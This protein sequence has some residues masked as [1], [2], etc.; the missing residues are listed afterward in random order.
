MK[1]LIKYLLLKKSLVI[2]LLVKIISKLKLKKRN[3]EI[4]I[5]V[6]LAVLKMKNKEEL[7]TQIYNLNDK[8]Y[9]FKYPFIIQEAT[10]IDVKNNT[11]VTGL[12]LK[13]WLLGSD[14]PLFKVDK[15][16][17]LTINK[18]NLEN[19]S[20]TIMPIINMY[21]SI[22]STIEFNDVKNKIIK[23]KKQVIIDQLNK[24]YEL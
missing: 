24:M 12:Q 8:Q 1:T 18:I 5:N 4:K 11:V 6:D 16:D 15:K 23:H 21:N 14:S 13:K 17:V 20:D 10:G 19:P 9:I 3:Y 7:I 22:I 2:I